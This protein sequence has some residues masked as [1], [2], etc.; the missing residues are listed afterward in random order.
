MAVNAKQDT[1]DNYGCGKLP[2]APT[3]PEIPQR[4]ECPPLCICPDPPGGAPK[5]CLDG[6]IE[7]Q[8]AIVKKAERAKEFAQEL[9]AIQQKMKSAQVEY[10]QARYVDLRSKWKEQDGAI[11]ELIRKL[12][13]AV[14]CWEC[15]LECRLCR[16][17]VE[18]RRQEDRLYGA[19]GSDPAGTGPLTGQV[20]SL[21]DQQAWHQR[22]VAQM[23]GR[24]QRITT[25]MAAWE[26]PAATLAE[27]LEKNGN[28]LAQV[29][30]LISSDPAKAMYDVF[31]TL[32][33]THWAI[34]PR[35][36]GLAQDFDSAI[37]RK[38]I[39]ICDCPRTKPPATSQHRQRCDDDDDNQACL[40]DDGVPDDCCGPDVGVL[41]LRERLIGPVPYIVD[42]LQFPVILCCLT[43]QRLAPASDQLA[44]AEAALEASGKEIERVLKQIADRTAGIETAFRAELG[45]PIECDQYKKANGPQPPAG[46][47]AQAPYAAS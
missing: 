28:L 33:P 45:N 12:V 1:E 10:T 25:V 46:G 20:Y 3:V 21:Y 4:A 2:E 9:A 32:L 11:V 36:A 47:G 35:G 22:N 17:L 5:D 44:A 42:P 30:G 15:L 24:L 34:R 31:M 27:V 38:Y 23:K 19:P 8:T 14:P 16:Q 7:G 41:S 40:C 18:I 13:C 6:L 29:Q 39:H 37:D 26:K 43:T